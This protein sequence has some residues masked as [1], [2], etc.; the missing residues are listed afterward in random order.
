MP[1]TKVNPETHDCQVPAITGESIGDE[2]T[3]EVCTAVWT[4]RRLKTAFANSGELFLERGRSRGGV[5][6]FGGP[7]T[8]VNPELTRTITPA[9]PARSVL[10]DEKRA[11]IHQALNELHSALYPLT[12]PI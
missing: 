7:V 5:I 9:K 2:W 12:G 4:V 11:S 10:T 6:N 1:W 3:C 8:P